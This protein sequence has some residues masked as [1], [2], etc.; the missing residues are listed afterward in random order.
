MIAV[1]AA[2]KN[3]SSIYTVTVNIWSIGGGDILDNRIWLD[4]D[5]WESQAEAYRAFLFLLKLSN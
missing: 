1:K 2:L 3:D 4:G 5:Q